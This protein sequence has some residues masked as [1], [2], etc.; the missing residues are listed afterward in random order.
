[1]NHLKPVAAAASLLLILSCAAPA[2]SN[3]GN[4]QTHTVTVLDFNGNTLK[5][6][7]VSDGSSVDLSSID[8]ASLEKHIDTYT[9]IGFSSWSSI[10]SKITADTTVRALYKKMVLSLDSL[11]SKTEYLDNYG[12]IDTKGLGVS[13]TVYT[14]LPEKDTDG[15]YKVAKEIVNIESE[16]KVSP[17][18][19]Q[20]AFASSNQA[21][22][23]IFPI[24]S[25]RPIAS[26]GITYYP[27]IG[28]ADMN[29]FIDSA[30]ATF[31]L[32]AYSAVSTGSNFTYSAGQKKRCDVDGNGK[33]DSTDA[34]LVLR[35]YADASVME[36]PTWSA[37]LNN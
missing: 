30:D 13:I 18:T 14:Q 21:E 12:N 7:T 22:I 24:S 25:S 35:F 4:A 23:S 16:C 15:N 3:A 29:G 26:Y 17:A 34:T 6:L 9:Q 36:H 31:I 2:S 33:V 1:M 28:D 37:V 32:G 19:L 20:E 27:N 8:T 11:P 10:P 5:T